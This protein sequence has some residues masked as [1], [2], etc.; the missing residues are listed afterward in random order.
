MSEIQIRFVSGI[1]GVTLPEA[2]LFVP[3][4]LKK[5]GLSEVVSHILGGG[6]CKA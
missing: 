5:S 1:Q 6:S 2:P 4:S 3:T